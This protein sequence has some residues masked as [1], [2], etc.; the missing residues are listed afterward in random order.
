MN[1]Y[2][3]ACLGMHFACAKTFIRVSLS[4]NAV[5]LTVQGCDSDDMIIGESLSIKIVSKNH[6]I[7]SLLISTRFFT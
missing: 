4:L 6:S 2:Q 7:S 1:R 3:S 5:S